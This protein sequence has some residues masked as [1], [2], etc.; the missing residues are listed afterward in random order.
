M[1]IPTAGLN[2]GP[3]YEAGLDAGTIQKVCGAG[4]G[5]WGK[6]TYSCL[7]ISTNYENIN[8]RNTTEKYS[9]GMEPEALK[10]HSANNK[11]WMETSPTHKHYLRENEQSGNCAV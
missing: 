6:L 3:R 1:D 11:E 10:T 4:P 5:F 8:P 9:E 2:A 7:K